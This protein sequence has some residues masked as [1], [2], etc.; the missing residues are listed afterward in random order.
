MSLAQVVKSKLG[1]AGVTQSM[2]RADK[3]D[4]RPMEGFFGTL[5]AEMFYGKN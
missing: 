1:K 3:I 5:K 4:N 2:S